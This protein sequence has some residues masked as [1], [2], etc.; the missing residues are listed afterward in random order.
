MDISTLGHGVEKRYAVPSFDMASIVRGELQGM[1][2]GKADTG[3]PGITSLVNKMH[4]LSALQKIASGGIGEIGLGLSASLLEQF[5]GIGAIVD[6]SA[7][8]YRRGL[9]LTSLDQHGGVID[10]QLEKAQKSLS[11]V[12]ANTMADLDRPMWFDAPRLSPMPPN[13]IHET[14]GHLADLKEKFDALVDI[15]VKQDAA[16]TRTAKKVNRLTIL[17]IVLAT[18]LGSVSIAAAIF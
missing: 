14:N 6:D 17:N 11:D 3:T 8:E 2:D 1:N 10:E 13:P 9:G 16:Q 7:A 18:I 15:Q 4:E 5:R 12:L